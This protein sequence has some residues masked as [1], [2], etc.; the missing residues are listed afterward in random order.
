MPV[1]SRTLSQGE[2]M[3][4]AQ[5][6]PSPEAKA[7]AEFSKEQELFAYRTILTIRRFEEKTGRMSGRGLIGGLFRAYIVQ[8]AGVA[9]MQI[10]PKPGDQVITGYRDPGHMR[11]TGMDAKGVMAELTGRTNGYSKRK[12]GSMHM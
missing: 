9:G 2:T 10:A 12:G 7:V 6:I 8:E 4:V 11:A 3:A 5:K 1:N